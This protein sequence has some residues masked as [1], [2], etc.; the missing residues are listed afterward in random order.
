MPIT[1]RVVSHVGTDR[2]GLALCGLDDPL[3]GLVH[4]GRDGE[5]AVLQL[6][7]DVMRD[8]AVQR[9]PLHILRHPHML[10]E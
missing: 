10:H 8:L 4:A 2:V 1:P 9:R 7:I 3:L 6:Y 5:A